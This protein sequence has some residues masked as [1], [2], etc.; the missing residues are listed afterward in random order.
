MG[1]LRLLDLPTND[2]L[3]LSSSECRIDCMRTR[4]ECSVYFQTVSHTDRKV[5]N[6]PSANQ[7][8]QNVAF[9]RK[10]KVEH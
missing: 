7:H 3:C 2:C 4:V 9:P 5:D 10:L 6:Y 8:I 1:P